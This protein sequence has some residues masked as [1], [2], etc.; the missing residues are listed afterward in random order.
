MKAKIALVFLSSVIFTFA[1][2]TRTFSQE[3]FNYEKALA[4]YVFTLNNYQKEHSEYLLARSQFQQA[5]TLASETKAIVETK[6][7]LAAR[8]EVVRT[9]L[10]ALRLRLIESEGIDQNSKETIFARLDSEAAWFNDHKQRVGSAG[11]LNDLVADSNE[12][13]THFVNFTEGVIFETLDTLPLGKITILREG[14][15]KTLNKAEEKTEK[16]RQKGDHDTSIVERWIGQTDNTLTRS[17]DKELDARKIV[18]RIQSG[19][20]E[21]GRKTINNKASHNNVLRLASE[22]LQLM[23]N[24]NGFLKEVISSIRTKS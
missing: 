7:M 9:Y 24:A 15:T 18:L 20:D 12:A 8:D 5:R 10:T 3:E 2:T 22:S 1:A 14:L 6:D 23:K 4:D 19:V 17:L 16:I 21:R 13:R 11:T